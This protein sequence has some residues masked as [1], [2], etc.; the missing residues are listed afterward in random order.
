[1]SI[2]YQ[3]VELDRILLEAMR[4]AQHLATGQ[5]L[6]LGSFE[7]MQLTGDADR[8]KQLLLILLDNA[9]KYTPTDGQVTMSLCQH[10]AR[11]VVEV[12]DTG[13]GISLEALPHV[14]ERFYRA[15]PARSQ[16]PGGTGLGLA[17]ARWI[18]EQHGGK[19]ALESEPGQGTIVTVLLP[20]DASRS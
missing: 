19:I 5:R 7:P 12:R 3:T 1:M 9:L 8:L 18:V 6:A 15:D 13:V 4:D 17:I 10:D 11:A 2:R 14:F 20:R 16:D